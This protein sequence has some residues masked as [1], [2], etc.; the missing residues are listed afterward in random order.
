MPRR[1]LTSGR[2]FSIT[3]S[4]FTTILFRTSTPRGCLR[5][6]VIERLLRWRLRKSKPI[7]VE[8]PSSSWRA[9]TL[10]TEAPMSASWRTAVGPERAGAG[11]L[12]LHE[13]GGLEARI[14]LVARHDERG[15]LA[16]LHAFAQLEHGRPRHLDASKRQRVTLGRAAGQVLVELL[17][18]DGVLV[19]ELHPRRALGVEVGRLLHA[20]G[21]ELLRRHLGVLAE[22]FTVGHHA[23]VAGTRHHDGQ[24]AI[25]IAEREVE[26]GVPALG[27]PAHVG[28]LDRERVEEAAE[29]FDGAVLRVR[30]RILGDV[31]RR[32]AAG[33][34]GDRP[35]APREELHL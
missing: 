10:M 11:Q 27:E 6:R 32:V 12:A 34:V 16:L 5:S 21:L 14:V 3:T 15:Y 23:A 22:L 8:S 19:L 4:A 7:A 13:D 20:L 24:Q 31:R 35:V 28:L 30:F 9:S 25:G 26:R 33:V 18:A 1:C 29:V 2:K 17:E